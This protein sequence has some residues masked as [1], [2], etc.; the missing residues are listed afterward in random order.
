MLIFDPV[1][2]TDTTNRIGISGDCCSTRALY[3]L[4]DFKTIRFMVSQLNPQHKINIKM[5]N[6]LTDKRCNEQQGDHYG[7]AHCI[8]HCH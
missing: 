3:K 2:T 6:S 7:I 5:V 8:R 4:R 1:K